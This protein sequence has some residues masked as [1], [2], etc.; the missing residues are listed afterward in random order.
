MKVSLKWLQEYIDI[1][2]P[3]ADLT[4]RLTL[5]GTEVKGKETISSDW[6]NIVV[7]QIVAVNPHPNADR[8]SLPTV[9]LGTEQQAVVCGAPNLKIGDKVAFARVGAKLIDGHSG[10]H[11]LSSV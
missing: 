7:G 4:T 3:L 9:N 6:E 5:A 11:D 10:P 8:L 2:L 1:N